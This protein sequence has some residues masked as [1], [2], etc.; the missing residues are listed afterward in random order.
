MSSKNK[1]SISFR[2]NQRNTNQTVKR[3][4]DEQAASAEP[5]DDKEWTEKPKVY[6]L[7]VPK[8]KR[9]PSAIKPI[10]VSTATALLI[11][12]GLGFLLLRMFVSLT[13][14]TTNGSESMPVPATSTGS[15]TEE[16]ATIGTSTL[17]GYVIQAGVFSTEEKATEWKMKLTASAVSSAIWERDGQYYLFVG[18]AG[19][20]AEANEIADDLSARD[21]ET[22]V[23]P[24]TVLSERTSIE[25]VEAEIAEQVGDYVEDHKMN[26]LTEEQRQA[27][28]LTLEDKAPDSPLLDLFKNWESSDKQ[29]LN[30]IHA[31]KAFE[32]IT[33]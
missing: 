27:Y 24:W 15:S 21:V 19:S 26:E 23:K 7:P 5:D 11:S 29:Q 25:G 22:Y 10:L 6:S 33:E 12:F 16:T 13:D 28:L 32:E 1:I 4:K 9:R 8:K 3:A 20:E 17:D 31:S 14:E 18:S 2:E 30:W